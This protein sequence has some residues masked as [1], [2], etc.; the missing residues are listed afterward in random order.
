MTVATASF[1]GMAARRERWNRFLAPKAEGGFLFLISVNHPS[2][3]GP[4]NPWP[5][6]NLVKERIEAAWRGYERALRDAELFGDDRVPCLN[7]Y[8]GT[9]IFAEAFGCAVHRP[10]ED[11]PFALPRVHAPAEAAR[12]KTP[13][14]EETPLM[15][16][17]EIAAE[18][19]RRGG[20]D[21]VMK[22]PDIQSPMDIAA[23][24][25]EK[26][27]F[28][29]AMI[30]EPE[31]VQEL[32]GKVRALLMA[33]LDEWF[34]R[35]GKA[36]V[37]HYPDY[38]MAQGI[39]LSED[40]IGAVNTDMFERL[41]RPE[42]TELSNRYGGLGV[43]CC[44]DARHQWSGLA[45]VPGLRVLNLCSPPQRNAAEYVPDACRFFQDVCGQMHFGWNPPGNPATWP[46]QF[47]PRARVIL[48]P[49]VESDEDGRRLCDALN[50][51]REAFLSV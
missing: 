17:F 35:F 31:A 39:T 42:L 29:E 36:F 30:D 47:P 51:Q 40:E 21:A 41:F 48:A 13:R 43:H 14:L 25:W 23:L 8:T 26:A 9:E 11:M 32:A 22:L 19:R 5:W 15:V 1:T 28:L 20:P 37:A 50:A 45:R 12:L 2:R 6:P 38:Y 27:A 16:L 49:T 33:F 7:P 10:A 24:I 46:A 44:A 3:Q 18:L 34:R 4:R